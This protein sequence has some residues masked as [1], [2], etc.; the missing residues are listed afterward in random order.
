MMFPPY[1]NHT[2]SLRLM[3]DRGNRF[4]CEQFAFL[5]IGNRLRGKTGISVCFNLRAILQPKA[6]EVDITKDLQATHIKKNGNTG[7]T[8]PGQKLLK[9]QP[10]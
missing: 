1:N 7:Q 9:V 10:T 5:D 3:A 6:S 8:M 4:V 2:Q